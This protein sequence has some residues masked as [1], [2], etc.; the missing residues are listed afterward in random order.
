MSCVS[1]EIER[2]VRELRSRATLEIGPEGN[3]CNLSKSEMN[4]VKYLMVAMAATSSYNTEQSTNRSF[5]EIHQILMKIFHL[6]TVNG[7]NCKRREAFSPT[8]GPS[9]IN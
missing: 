9:E 1:E 8:K 2:R 3:K 5:F 4:L 7:S 6:L